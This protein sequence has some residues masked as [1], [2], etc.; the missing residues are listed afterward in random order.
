[1]LSSHTKESVQL[2]DT[3][4]RSDQPQAVHCTS[5]VSQVIIDLPVGQSEMQVR[6]RILMRR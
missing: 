2:I 6:C 3:V 4:D 1:M 5:D